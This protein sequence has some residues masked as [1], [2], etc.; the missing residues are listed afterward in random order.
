MLPQAQAR[1]WWEAELERNAKRHLGVVARLRAAR[2]GGGAA[3]G[4]A[5]EGGVPASEKQDVAGEVITWLFAPGGH[6]PMARVTAAGGCSIVADQVGAP[7]VVLDDRGEVKAQLVVDSRGQAVVD[8]D[9]CGSFGDTTF[10][11]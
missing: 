1:A 3:E 10:I 4:V 8:G 11:T 2:D 5:S 7:L 6:A 9:G